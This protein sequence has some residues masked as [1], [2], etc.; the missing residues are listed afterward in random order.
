MMIQSN[1]SS[2]TSYSDSQPDKLSIVSG[3]NYLTYRQ[4]NRRINRLANVLNDLGVRKGDRVNVLLFNTNEL[5]E[6]LFACAKIEAIF[7]P[8][9]YRLSA[10]EVEY[11]VLESGGCV[12]IHDVR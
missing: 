11:I 12:F 8:I 7:V 5:M 3:D 1:G 9:N 2:I 10:D 6:T 4:I